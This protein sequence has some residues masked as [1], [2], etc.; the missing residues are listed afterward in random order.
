MRRSLASSPSPWLRAVAILLVG[1]LAQ[2]VVYRIAPQ[3]ILEAQRLFGLLAL[4]AIVISGLMAAYF[5]R[6]FAGQLLPSALAP[7]Y[8]RPHSLGFLVFCVVG[9]TPLMTAVLAVP[10]LTHHIPIVAIGLQFLA[11]MLLG[12]VLLD[13]PFRSAGNGLRTWHDMEDIAPFDPG[14]SRDEDAFMPPLPPPSIP[15]SH[16]RIERQR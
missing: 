16:N 13:P 2:G 15:Q 7:W 1:G 6:N 3:T 5:L 11:V 14:P 4:A 12:I 9:G 10:I 8:V